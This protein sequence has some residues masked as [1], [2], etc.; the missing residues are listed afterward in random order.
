[1]AGLADAGGGY[2]ATTGAA[3]VAVIVL[4]GGGLGLALRALPRVNSD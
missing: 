2:P 4:F 3:I 1:M